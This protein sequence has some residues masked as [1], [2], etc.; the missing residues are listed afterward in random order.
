MPKHKPAR[1]AHHAYAVCALAVIIPKIGPTLGFGRAA[2]VAAAVAVAPASASAF[3]AAAAVAV[4]LCAVRVWPHR[5]KPMH[6]SAQQQRPKQQ[7]QQ[8]EQQE[9]H[10]RR[11]LT[12]R[13]GRACHP[14]SATGIYR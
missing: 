9:I 11:R 5:A 14:C 3:A 2:A 1:L 4:L 8:R 13:K 12:Y 7:Q 10:Q 6:L